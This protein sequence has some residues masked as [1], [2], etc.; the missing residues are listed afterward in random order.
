MATFKFYLWC[1]GSEIW[2]LEEATKPQIFN[3]QRYYIMK[4]YMALQR[5]QMEAG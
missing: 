3:I 5:N 2:L 4:E 1:H